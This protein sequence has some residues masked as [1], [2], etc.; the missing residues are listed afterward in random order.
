M[1]GACGVQQARVGAA[2]LVQAHALCLR[3]LHTRLAL[4]TRH[5]GAVGEE[6]DQMSTR[7]AAALCR[8]VPLHKCHGLGH[9][10]WLPPGH[11][12][13]VGVTQWCQAS[14]QA[15]QGSMAAGRI[16]LAHQEAG[17]LQQEDHIVA[18]SGGVRPLEVSLEGC[19]AAG[20]EVAVASARPPEILDA[21]SSDDATECLEAGCAGMELRQVIAHIVTALRLLAPLQQPSSDEFQ[22]VGG[23][24]PP[25]HTEELVLVVQDLDLLAVVI[26]IIARVDEAL[27]PHCAVACCDSACLREGPG[28]C[29]G[30]SHSGLQHRD[31][32]SLGP[33]SAS[34]SHR[35]RLRLCRLL[36]WGPSHILTLARHMLVLLQEV[37]SRDAHGMHSEVADGGVVV[38]QL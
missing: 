10:R 22:R 11:G 28:G 21:V 19:D 1:R 12:V 2:G 24:G 27:V 7:S 14:G 26:L 3:T 38:A 4:R 8:A 17:S 18:L 9:R 25:Q 31:V 15:D 30:K 16:N 5:E 34:G 37:A 29:V 13:E 6:G 23:G 35:L 36:S 32:Y 20:H 33:A